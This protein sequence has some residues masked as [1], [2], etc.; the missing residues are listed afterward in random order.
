MIS[1]VNI[2]V[3]RDDCIACGACVD[4]CIMDNLRLSVAPCR[5]ACPLDINCQGY[6]R[7]LARD[8]GREAAVEL[9]KH[10]PFAAIL[11]RIC[12]QPCEKA[13]ERGLKTGDGAVHIRAVK[14]YL[15]DTYPDVVRAPVEQ[16]P[17]TGKTVGI[18]GSGPAGMQA[19]YDLAAAGHAVTVYEAEQ[20][21]GGMLR[22][23][24]PSYRLPESVL[25]QAFDDLRAMGVNFITGARLG[26]NLTLDELRQRHNA[27]VLALGLGR[28]L[29]PPVPGADLPG[30]GTALEVLKAV[31]EQG[32]PSGVTSVT[33]VGGGSTAMDV[34]L[35]LKKLGIAKVSLVALESR[36][37]MLVPA[38]EL[39]EARE[40]GVDVL[41]RW[42]VTAIEPVGNDLRLKLERCLEVFDE[43]GRFAPELDPLTSR[44]HDT[45]MVIFATGQGLAA[46]SQPLPLTAGHL[47]RSCP[48]TG[49]LEGTEAVFVAGDCTTGP[50][51]VVSAMASGKKIAD[52]LHRL[53]M[54]QRPLALDR[55]AEDGKVREF[56]SH[57]ERAVGGPRMELRTRPAAERSFALEVEL[58][59]TP[60]EAMAEASRC[61]AC[62]RAFE[63]NKTCWFCLPCEIDCPHSALTVNMP[64]LV[65]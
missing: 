52:C 34:A 49:L 16:L 32:G 12:N 62:G 43:K 14:R 61:L 60:A 36:R 4:R 37:E 10:T 21:L 3:N 13:C 58:A 59:L 17:A 46:I 6:L 64:Y 25:D 65:R 40:E 39:L 22:Y 41:N 48:E 54:E 30:V 28:S 7:L 53:L 15:A 50:G 31:K 1:D 11:G 33:V 45:A 35:S 63:A 42:A 23:G 24:V 47:V 38:T 19:A 56:E 27:V 55:W 5:Q 57:P 2:Q 20:R 26:D 44:D 51:S 9:R 29:V 18:V 8:K